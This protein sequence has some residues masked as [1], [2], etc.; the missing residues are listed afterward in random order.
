MFMTAAP[1]L[2]QARRAFP[3]IERI[4]ADGVTRML[5]GIAGEVSLTE[6]RR[7]GRRNT[8]EPG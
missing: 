7:F 4:Y 5:I 8:I 1:V 2:R 3:L 6:L